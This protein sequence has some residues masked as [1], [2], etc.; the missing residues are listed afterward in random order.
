MSKLAEEITVR[1]LGIKRLQIELFDGDT[2]R[3]IAP[4][5]LWV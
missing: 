2:L 4:L 5:S 1:K 3:L